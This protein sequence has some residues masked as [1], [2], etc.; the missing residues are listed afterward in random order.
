MHLSGTDENYKMS[1]LYLEDYIESEQRSYGHYCVHF[2]YNFIL[3]YN[4]IILFVVIEHLPQELKDRFTEIR[5]LDLQVQ[6]K[7]P[8]LTLL[9][10]GLRL[11]LV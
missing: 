3:N 6:S 9:G 10:N 5:E 7:K 2:L 4:A 8:T 11:E 1:M